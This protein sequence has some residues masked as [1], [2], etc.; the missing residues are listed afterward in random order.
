MKKFGKHRN[1]VCISSF[2]NCRIGGKDPAK[3][4]DELC[5]AAYAKEKC[6]SKLE[7]HFSFGFVD[8]MSEIV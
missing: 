5:G 3:A 4:A 6:L 1:T 2:L 8:I 7:R